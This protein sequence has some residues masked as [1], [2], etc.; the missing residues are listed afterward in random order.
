M[1]LTQQRFF[2]F[3]LGHLI[4]RICCN[5][6]KILKVRC[7]FLLSISNAFMILLF[8][9]VLYRNK[10]CCEHLI[11]LTSNFQTFFFYLGFFSQTF[12]N[13]RTAGKGG[14]HFFNSSLPF[15]SAS[16]ALRYWPDDYCGELTSA[17]S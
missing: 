2:F 16:Q 5:K 12:A 4:L 15:P 1:S 17:H 9:I 11:I 6:I 13:H 3:Y 14:R 7:S 10:L 8:D